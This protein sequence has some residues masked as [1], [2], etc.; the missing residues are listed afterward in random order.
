M[1][2][3]R[4]KIT[5]MLLLGASKLPAIFPRWLVSHAEHLNLRLDDDK[6]EYHK[7]DAAYIKASLLD[8][9]FHIKAV[10]IVLKI[11]QQELTLIHEWLRLK[12]NPGNYYPQYDKDT[13][14]ARFTQG[15]IPRT[16]GWVSINSENHYHNLANIKVNDAHCSSCYSSIQKFANGLCYLSL[17]FMVKEDRQSL[18]SNLDVN[19]IKQS[20]SL[21]SLN[22]FSKQFR[23]LQH[24]DRKRNIKT[25][26]KNNIN[27]LNK[28][29]IC[30]SNKVLG[31]WG[32]K[33]E[34]DDFTS[35]L[36]IVVDD[37]APYFEKADN[38]NRPE[39]DSVILY[40]RF[41]YYMDDQFSDNEAEH[42]CHS[43]IE[44]KELSLDAIFIKSEAQNSLDEHQ[45]FTRTGKAIYD[46][47]LYFSALLSCYKEYNKSAHFINDSL[48][49]SNT[50]PEKHY[51]RLFHS[52]LELRQLKLDIQ[53]LNKGIKSSCRD[54]YQR[55]AKYIAENISNLIDELY[56]SVEKQI[57]FARDSVQAKNL[58]FHRR[59]S[60]I[61]AVL[62]ITQIWIAIDFKG[63][64]NILIENKHHIFDQAQQ[65]KVEL[66]PST[67]KTKVKHI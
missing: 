22:P 9:P 50:L 21:S 31:L 7:R 18:F 33:K 44:A 66:L 19:N 34:S 4:H 55:S 1:E 30:Y 41:S 59:Y 46:S 64:K 60:Y 12:G 3:Y 17:Y 42:Y 27:Q 13:F 2:Y 58:K 25:A 26:L 37:N 52:L 8:K 57:E 11:N 35:V 23:V 61:I 5:K 24:F 39:I 62:V 56:E 28:N 65:E 14:Q 32:I 15:D 53:A 45:S 40:D 36:D 43:D 63:V 67:R 49:N 6:S 20:Y 54:K 10:S 29:V 48:L 38:Q 47:H 16:L 51:G